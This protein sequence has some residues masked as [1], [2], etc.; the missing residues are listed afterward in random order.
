MDD[1]EAGE[2]LVSDEIFNSGN[3]EDISIQGLDNDNDNDSECSS[4]LDQHGIFVCGD[5]LSKAAIC[6]PDNADDVVGFAEPRTNET[7]Y[8]NDFEVF[9]SAMSFIQVSCLS[10]IM[11]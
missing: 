4:C 3:V 7:G 9:P 2:S 6:T 10:F 11:L 8:D 1:S 5:F